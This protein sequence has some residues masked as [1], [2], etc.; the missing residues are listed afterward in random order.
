M[1]DSGEWSLEP[2]EDTRVSERSRMTRGMTAYGESLW[3]REAARK[4]KHRLVL[5]KK[6]AAKKQGTQSWGEFQQANR[7][8]KLR[9]SLALSALAVAALVGCVQYL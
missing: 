9:L 7:R 3:R 5:Q 4:T 2:V 8:L 6:R 1:Q